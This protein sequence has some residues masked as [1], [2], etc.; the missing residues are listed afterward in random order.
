MKTS[1]VVPTTCSFRADR[2]IV[3][4]ET[5]SRIAGIPERGAANYGTRRSREV[6][7]RRAVG[8]IRLLAADEPVTRELLPHGRAERAGP[9]P[10]DD[11]NAFEAR[12]RRCVD[13]RPHRLAR[14][15]RPEPA[16]VELVGHVGA[17]AREH[18]HGRLRRRRRDRPA[19]GGPEAREPDPET[20]PA[21]P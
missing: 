14:L 15:L 1:Q 18:P 19:R 4:R 10:V 6:N 2:S 21:R 12:E 3:C 13:E 9:A 17:A 8:G 16:Y 5:R 20:K 7:E 11:A